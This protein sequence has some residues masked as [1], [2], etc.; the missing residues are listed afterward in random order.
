[1]RPKKI[2]WQS[3]AVVNLL[4]NDSIPLKQ[5]AEQLGVSYYY[6]VRKRRALGLPLFCYGGYGHKST[7][8]ERKARYNAKI[9]NNKY[10]PLS[11]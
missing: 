7:N 9:K 2:D 3:P 1:M 5:K 8:Q 6:V 4:K 10:K 11:L